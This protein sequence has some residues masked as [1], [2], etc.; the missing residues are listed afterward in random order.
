[1]SG[2]PGIGGNGSDGSAIYALVQASQVPIFDALPYSFKAGRAGINGY[3][4][5]PGTPGKGGLEGGSGGNCKPR[6]RHGA[7]G[8]VPAPCALPEILAHWGVDGPRPTITAYTGFEEL[9]N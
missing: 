7:N 4:G 2:T 1:V 6:G 8:V 9:G 5:R 3:L